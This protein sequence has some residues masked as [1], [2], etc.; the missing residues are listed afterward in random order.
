M[1]DRNEEKLAERFPSMRTAPSKSLENFEAPHATEEEPPHDDAAEATAD[2]I[3]PQDAVRNA[4]DALD[5]ARHNLRVARDTL[6]RA[7]ENVGKRLAEYNQATP[8]ISAEQNVRD[9]IASNNAARAARAGAN[10]HY[11]PTVTQTAKAMSGGYG[12][13]IRTRRGGGAAYRRGPGGVQAY[14]KAQA[15]TIEA[16]KIRAA[17]A[18]AKLPNE[19]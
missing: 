3:P 5:V 11:Q 15:Q 8:T 4:T 1:S 12:N 14:T 2:A 7:R 6:A 18:A 13:D 9:W 16:G 10:G 17:R 19:R